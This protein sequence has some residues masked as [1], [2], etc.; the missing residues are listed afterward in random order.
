MRTGSVLTAFNFSFLRKRLRPGKYVRRKEK[1]M[2]DM[3]NADLEVLYFNNQ[4]ETIAKLV[5]AKA[6]T[7]EE[8]VA[9]IRDCKLKV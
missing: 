5:E 4:L 2:R 1:H 8:A 7:I 3:N 6:S 9:V